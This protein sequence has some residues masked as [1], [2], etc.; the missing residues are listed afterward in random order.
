MPFYNVSYP[1]LRRNITSIAVFEVSLESI[2]AH[3][4]VISSGML[5]CSPSHSFPQQLNVMGCD[6][7][8]VSKDFCDA[9]WDSHL[10]RLVNRRVLQGEHQTTHFIDTKIRIGR[11]YRSS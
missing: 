5:L 4:N 6:S 1:E 11:D 2:R 3:L 9:N 7:L 10:E 8:G